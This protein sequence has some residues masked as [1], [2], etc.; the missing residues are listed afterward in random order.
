MDKANANWPTR[1][2]VDGGALTG[3][4]SDCPF[5]KAD[6]WFASCDL[7]IDES[8]DPNADVQVRKLGPVLSAGKS[9]PRMQYRGS[10]LSPQQLEQLVPKS[11]AQVGVVTLVGLGLLWLAAVLVDRT[12]AYHS[13]VRVSKML[14]AMLLTATVTIGAGLLLECSWAERHEILWTMT[15]S[16]WKVIFPLAIGAALLVGILDAIGRAGFC[17]LY[18][19]PSPRDRTRSRMPSSA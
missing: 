10:A 16:H 5:P 15:G 2:A 7:S 11:I 13:C 6:D 4:G 3:D 14:Y 17:L 12:D 8:G 9:I 19:S 1:I 18:T